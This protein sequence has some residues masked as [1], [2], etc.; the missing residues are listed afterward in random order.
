[1]KRQC[2]PQSLEYSH[3]NFN[4]KTTSLLIDF[5][6]VRKFIYANLDNQFILT[7]AKMPLMLLFSGLYVVNEVPWGIRLIF[8]NNMK[9]SP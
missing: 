7:C 1:M 5:F 9:T 2:Q 6:V 4:A 8:G 3:T